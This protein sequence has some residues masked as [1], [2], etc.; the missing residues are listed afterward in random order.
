[1]LLLPDLL[2]LPHLPLLMYRI[3][4]KNSPSTLFRLPTLETMAV[5]QQFTVL[6]PCSFFLAYD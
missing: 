4:P 5:A 1:M 2:P 3:S 6:V